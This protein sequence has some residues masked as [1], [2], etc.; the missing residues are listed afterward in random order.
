M[1]NSKNNIVIPEAMS[2]RKREKKDLA[3]IAKQVKKQLNLADFD[4]VMFQVDAAIDKKLYQVAQVRAELQLLEC[5][6]QLVI[7]KLSIDQVSSAQ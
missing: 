6:R 3:W 1:L 7:Y 5:Y 2:S 4:S